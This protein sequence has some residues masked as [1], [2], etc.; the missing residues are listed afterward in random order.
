MAS[1]GRV[2]LE[3]GVIRVALEGGMVRYPA[4]AATHAEDGGESKD[5]THTWH[6]TPQRHNTLKM[7][8]PGEPS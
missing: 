4:P 2:A 5:L 1:L 8:T 6:V 7:K 3:G